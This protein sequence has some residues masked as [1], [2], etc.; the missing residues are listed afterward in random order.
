MDSSKTYSEVI[1]T[2]TYVESLKA[3]RDVIAEQIEGGVLARDL[4]SLTRRLLDIQRELLDLEGT[5]EEEESPAEKAARRRAERR[6]AAAEDDE[7]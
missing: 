1:S 2:G 6:R 4:A 7:D 5:G 3:T